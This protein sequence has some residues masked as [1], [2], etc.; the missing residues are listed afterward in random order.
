L[1]LIGLP[2]RPYVL[3]YESRLAGMKIS[4]YAPL[5]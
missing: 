3:R 4:I 1:F 2:V 5:C